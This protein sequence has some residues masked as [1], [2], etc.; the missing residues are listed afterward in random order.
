MRIEQAPSA[1][2]VAL[3]LSEVGGCF[4][5]VSLRL[6][7]LVAY[8]DGF[9]FADYLPAFHAV[10]FDQAQRGD[11]AAD[12]AGD[13]DLGRFDYPDDIDLAR[14]GRRPQVVVAIPVE[15]VTQGAEDAEGD[16][17]ADDPAN[18]D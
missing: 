10:A 14:I 12:A 18:H 13:I 5:H 2:H 6:L 8:I 3:G 11:T 17:A 15:A 1:I 16:Q 9:D 7:Q 4:D